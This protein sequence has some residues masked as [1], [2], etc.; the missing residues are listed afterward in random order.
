M[1]LVGAATKP[2]ALEPLRMFKDEVNVSGS[3]ASLQSE[4]RTLVDLV[5][6]KAL[7]VKDMV[8]HTFPLEKINEAIDLLA[9]RRERALRGVI[10]LD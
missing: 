10:R 3:Y 1:I 6:R 8:T 9:A 7:A 5:A 2:A 4:V